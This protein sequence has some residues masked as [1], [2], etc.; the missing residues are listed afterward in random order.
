MND[1]A[2]YLIPECK[3]CPDWST[4]ESWTTGCLAMTECKF[5]SRNRK[6]HLYFYEGP[7][8][9]FDVYIDPYWSGSTLAV[10]EAKAKSNLT[11]NYKIDHGYLP[12]TCITLPGEII[13][14][15]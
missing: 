15:E 6:L 12:N 13:M 8:K 10:S 11:Y 14:I 4:D 1:Y 5:L 9:Y 2:G 3:S 7:V